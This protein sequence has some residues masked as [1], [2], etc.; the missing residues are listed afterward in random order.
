M[1]HC[2]DIIL[3]DEDYTYLVEYIRNILNGFDN[4]KMILLVGKERTGKSFLM[5][6]IK[7]IIGA[8]NCKDNEEL[9]NIL[10]TP[11]KPLVL[12]DGYLES[13]NLK[14][15]TLLNN[16]IQYRQSIISSVRSVDRISTELLAN[17]R[18]IYL[19]HEF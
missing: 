11:S 7:S 17:C 3:E 6:E 8:G 5:R 18:V 9:Y 19:S 14:N 16:L 2:Y 15:T 4:E 12:L 1:D 10:Y 13:Y